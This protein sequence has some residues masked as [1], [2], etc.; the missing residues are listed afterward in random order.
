MPVAFYFDGVD[1]IDKPEIEH[2]KSEITL[3][4]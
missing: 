3:I 4:V 2:P 1:R